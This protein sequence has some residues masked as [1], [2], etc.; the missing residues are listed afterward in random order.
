[1]NM[2]VD[3]STL[4]GVAAVN[5]FIT[6]TIVKLAKVEKGWVKQLISWL[7]PVVICIVGLLCQLGIFADYGT[8]ASWQGWVLTLVTGLGLGLTSNGLYDLPFV[9]KILE[10]IESLINKRKAVEEEKPTAIVPEMVPVS[11]EEAPAV[12]KTVKRKTTKKVE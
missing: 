8:I 9:Q 7:T 5:V 4:A 11:E 2:I 3:F 12:K 1:M 6:E 10:W